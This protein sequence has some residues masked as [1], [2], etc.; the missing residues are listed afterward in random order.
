MLAVLLIPGA[1]AF[2]LDGILIGAGRFRS[3]STMMIKVLAVY[4][5]TIAI[6]LVVPG[7]GVV[8]IWA[9]LAAWM[10]A[11]ALLGWRAATRDLWAA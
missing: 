10:A 9:A 3:L 11:R 2:G 5:P 6:A 4:V 8:G 7:V 1:L